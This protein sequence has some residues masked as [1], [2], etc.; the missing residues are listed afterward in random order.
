MARAIWNGVV[1]AE[2]DATVMVEGNHYF[3]PTAVKR[4]Y[5]PVEGHGQLL[6][7][8]RR[9]RRQQGRGLVLPRAEGGGTADRRPYRLLARRAC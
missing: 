3:P 7:R 9:G 1:I 4:E 5:L 8:S 6:R 2:S